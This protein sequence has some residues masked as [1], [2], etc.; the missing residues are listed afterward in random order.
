VSL[1]ERLPTI[2]HVAG[3]ALGAGCLAS[4]AVLAAPAAS[5]APSAPAASG[6]PAAPG[7]AG[8][9]VSASVVAPP[10]VAASERS[11][12]W[13]RY[14]DVTNHCGRTF[15]VKVVVA[16]GFDGPC[17]TLDDSEGY[18]HSYGHAGRLDRVDLC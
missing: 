13:G 12:F 4:A 16:F 1:R 10:C 18:T 11:D 6:A 15:R 5:A 2:R 17:V 14:A 3:V 8:G 7:D 9:G